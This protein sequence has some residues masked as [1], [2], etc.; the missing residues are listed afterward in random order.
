V[1]ALIRP[2]FWRTGQSGP[3]DGLPPCFRVIDTARETKAL[4]SWRAR[5]FQATGYPS[6][7]TP[8]H[9]R[10]AKTDAANRLSFTAIENADQFQSARDIVDHR[11]KGASGVIGCAP[12][13]DNCSS[14]H[15]R[16]ATIIHFDPLNQVVLADYKVTRIQRPRSPAYAAL[17][18]RGAH[19]R[20]HARRWCVWCPAS[21]E[22]HRYR[23]SMW[24]QNF[25]E[26]VFDTG[27]SRSSALTMSCGVNSSGSGVDGGP[28]TMSRP[29][30]R[31][32]FKT[33]TST[34]SHRAMRS[35]TS[36]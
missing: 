22:V 1:P 2:K 25:A 4:R 26:A 14:L 9:A 7:P 30:L 19:C 33:T 34:F 11:H 24:W 32:R 23:N 17:P 6:S 3:N 10:H 36:R 13:N 20:Q 27:A 31:L 35:V 18:L 21:A 12:R 16:E 28:N 15:Q 29:C 8:P 5:L